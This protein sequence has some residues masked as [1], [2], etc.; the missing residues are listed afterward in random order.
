MISIFRFAQTNYRFRQ[1]SF[2]HPRRKAVQSS[3]DQIERRIHCDHEQL[4]SAQAQAYGHCCAKE[5]EVWN[6]ICFILC[7][8]Y[9]IRQI[10]K[11]V[12]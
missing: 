7:D 10:K 3:A 11:F 2:F 1:S 12:G 9:K 6:L 4:E 8:Y 5:Y